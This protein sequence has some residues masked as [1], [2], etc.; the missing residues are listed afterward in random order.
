MTLDALILSMKSPKV[1]AH[2]KNA[3][4]FARPILKRLR[5]AIHKGCPK[6][7]ETIKWQFP[8]FMHKDRVLCGMMNFKAHCALVF[9]KSALIV[10]EK[11][12]SAKVIL[13]DLRHI[14][15]LDDLPEGR[16]LLSYIKLAAQF[17]EK[18][19]KV[20]RREAK[21]V[22][23]PRELMIALRANPKA[24]KHFE[25]FSPSKRKDY[26]FWISSA[27]TEETLERRLETA[28]DLISQG[29][30]RLWKYGK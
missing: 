10:K 12:P 7:E 28:I 19:M 26:I 13:K 9:W 5:A 2:I 14:A 1:D 24:F 23:V 17:N 21:P 30:A 25:A 27:K 8:F 29:K 18:G 6:V 16:E 20:S 22:A 4:T 11:G 15:S 3:P